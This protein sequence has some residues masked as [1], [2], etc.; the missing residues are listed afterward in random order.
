MVIFFLQRN[1]RLFLLSTLFMSVSIFIGMRAPL[2]ISL[3]GVFSAAL[4][5]A[6][7]MRL[8]F[9][10]RTILCTLIFASAMFIYGVAGSSFRYSLSTGDWS[11]FSS[12]VGSDN[13]ILRAIT[14][15]EPFGIQSI[16]NEVLREHFTVPSKS[17]IGIAKQFTIFS[18]EM[19]LS[20][21]GFNDYFQ[22]YLF[23]EV[24]Y[25]MAN[26]IW[27]HVWSIGGWWLLIGFIVF[28]SFALALLSW[29]SM[30]TE[31][32]LKAFFIVFSVP[33]AFY[34][35]R[36]DLFYQI[37]LERRYVLCYI[38]VLAICQF[39]AILSRKKC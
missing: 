10:K 30:R 25:G 39:S 4:L 18:P 28:Y 27:A 26:N 21:K 7:S 13:F 19:G 11:I 14:E 36:N 24:T 37:T 34:I 9:H 22:P 31:G 8:G 5:Q 17:L 12:T 32:T 20:A 6:G 16:L 38:T 33:M 35:H 3:I 15:S 1:L 2:A 29:L 23:P